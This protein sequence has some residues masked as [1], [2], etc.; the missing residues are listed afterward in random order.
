VLSL[1]ARGPGMDRCKGLQSPACCILMEKD[2]RSVMEVL[3][4]QFG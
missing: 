3:A 2:M 1:S 4:H